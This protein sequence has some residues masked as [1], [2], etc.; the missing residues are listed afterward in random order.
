M[1]AA[2]R[3]VPVAIGL[4]LTLCACTPAP[5]KPSEQAPLVWPEE[6]DAAPRVA[7]VRQISC[8]AD[9]GIARTFL[10]RIGELIFGKPEQR[11]VRPMAVVVVNGVIYVADPGVQGG[12]GATT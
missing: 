1:L 7:F 5:L 8:P 10:R 4:L 11:L 12:K 2:R 3:C 9:I 6:L